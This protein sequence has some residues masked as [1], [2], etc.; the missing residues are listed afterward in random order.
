MRGNLLPLCN[1]ERLLRVGNRTW[2]CL[3]PTQIEEPPPSIFFL[4]SL[5]ILINRNKFFCFCFLF[6]I[7]KNT[8]CFSQIK[9]FFLFKQ[10]QGVKFKKKSLS[11]QY[12]YLNYH[13]R[14]VEEERIA[15][16]SL[17]SGV[18]GLRGACRK[19]KEFSTTTPPYAE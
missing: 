4:F 1:S 19:G 12:S 17:S 6:R 18:L 8:F 14:G 2:I 15:G 16:N 10:G 3:H 9:F 5:S 11:G 7:S 13:T